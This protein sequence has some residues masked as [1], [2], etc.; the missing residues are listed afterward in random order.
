MDSLLF[1]RYRRAGGSDGFAAWEFS[2]GLSSWTDAPAPAQVG[3]RL[4]EGFLGREL[5]ESRARIVNNVTHWATGLIASMQYGLV[6]GSLRRRRVSYGVPFG[7]GV[8]S[9]GY[10]VLPVAGIYRPIWRYDRR[11]LSRDLTAHLV[12]GLSTA[13]TFRLLSASAGSR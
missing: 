8:W 3:K 10:A 9:A 4:L 6:A 1:T 5:P 12:F 2:A 13:A 11:T 7:A